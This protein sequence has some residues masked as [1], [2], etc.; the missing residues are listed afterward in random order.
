ML[1]L[2]KNDA[3]KNMNERASASSLET[4]NCER[5]SQKAIW[6]T[7]RAP[8]AAGISMPIFTNKKSK[9]VA[10]NVNTGTDE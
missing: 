7:P 6:R 8:G 4:L 9:S 5:D 2:K 1:V 10:L 3:N